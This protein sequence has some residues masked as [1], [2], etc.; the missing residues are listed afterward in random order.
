M[1]EIRYILG[2]EQ[3]DGS[4]IFVK[5]APGESLEIAFNCF[6]AMDYRSI[7]YAK[8]TREVFQEL[9]EFNLYKLNIEV[10]NMEPEREKA[11]EVEI[12]NTEENHNSIVEEKPKTGEE[13]KEETGL[14]DG[15]ETN[16]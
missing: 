15:E 13:K 10:I 14:T 11:R 5:N 12:N 2:K 1:K 9:D 3:A 7:S 8:K 6:D 4:E 16:S